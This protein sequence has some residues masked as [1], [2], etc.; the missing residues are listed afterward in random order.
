MSVDGQGTQ[1]CRNIA[2]NFNRPSRVHERYSLTDDRRQTDGR[3]IAYSERERKC[4][5]AKKVQWERK[6]LTYL[7]PKFELGVGR[8]P[9]LRNRSTRSKV[10]D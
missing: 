5:F 9:T 3:A 2:E 4:T 8:S 6:R 7:L 10:K 1:R